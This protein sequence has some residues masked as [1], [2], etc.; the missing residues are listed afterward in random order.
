[1]CRCA[2]MEVD[3]HSVSTALHTGF[4]SAEEDR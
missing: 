4:P 3:T 2:A 1:M